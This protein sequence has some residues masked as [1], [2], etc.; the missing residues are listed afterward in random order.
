MVEHKPGLSDSEV[1]DAALRENRTLLT[2]DKD[3]G[4]LVYSTRK[5][6]G[7]VLFL[8]FPAS[9]RSSLGTAIVSVVE[10]HGDRLSKAFTVVQ[11]GRTRI[12]EKPR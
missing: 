5:G 8:R 10:R 3:F 2:E 1:I 12:S 6:S 9:A 7:G 11:P 4:R